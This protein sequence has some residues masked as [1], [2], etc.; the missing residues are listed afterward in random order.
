MCF[1]LCFFWKKC[2]LKKTPP[3]AKLGVVESG[4]I[5]HCTIR[6]PVE[7]IRKKAVEGGQDA[8]LTLETREQQGV[9]PMLQRCLPN[10]IH[11]F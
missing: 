1:F 7:N 8:P 6:S 5:Y 9:K 2:P 11:F 10:H 4:C 3:A